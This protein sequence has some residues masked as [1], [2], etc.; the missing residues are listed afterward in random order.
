M[1]GLGL[2]LLSS[3]RSSS[4]SWSRWRRGS[5]SWRREVLLWRRRSAGK[6]VLPGL[7][8]EEVVPK[9]S[10][11]P[12]P[13][14]RA[15]FLSP[16]LLFQQASLG[17]FITEIWASCKTKERKAPLFVT[18]PRPTAVLSPCLRACHLRVGWNLSLLP[19]LMASTGPSPPPLL[20]SHPIIFS[21]RK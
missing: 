13:H 16:Q 11:Y 6:Q 18:A 7:S 5:D 12:Q 3:H 15:S 1:R 2:L 21:R 9:G 14:G 10:P 17:S 8:Y 20:F 19:L 4:G